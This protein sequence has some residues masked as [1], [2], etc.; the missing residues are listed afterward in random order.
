MLMGGERELSVKEE[1]NQKHNTSKKN[2][3]NFLERLIGSAGCQGECLF[4]G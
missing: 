4:Q 3:D 1:K 2:W